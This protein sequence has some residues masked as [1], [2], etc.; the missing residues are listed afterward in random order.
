MT[1]SPWYNASAATLYIV[2]IGLV[3]N[4]GTQHAPKGGDTLLAPI[5]V[6]SLFTLSAAV[7]GYLFC[8]TPAM[9]YFDGKKKKAV[10]LFL[11]TVGV[12][13]FYTA[14]A[15]GILFTGVFR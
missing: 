7:M 5:A 12:F 13:A 10:N 2:V 15:M 11:Q 14:A 1:K 8:Y 3:M 6:I 4:W 9:L